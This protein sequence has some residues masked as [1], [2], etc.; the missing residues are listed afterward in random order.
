ML[1]YQTNF[2][3]KKIIF[4]SLAAIPAVAWAQDGAYTING[5][6]GTLN[7][8]AKAY[9]AYGRSMDTAEIKN[10]VFT[11][12][13]TAAKPTKAQI[14]VD[15]AGEG[16]MALRMKG[17]DIKPLYLEKGTITVTGKD[18]IYN[19][20]V[21]GTP[22]NVDAEKFNK[23]VEVPMKGMEALNK[24]YAAAPA[25]KKQDEAFVGGLRAKFEELNN[26]KNELAKKFIEQNPKSYLSLS[27]IQEIAGA[28]MDVAVVEPMFNKLD[29]SLRDSE[30]GKAFAKLI[31]A[32]HLTAVGVM[33]PDFTQN[34]VNDKPVKLSDF[35]GKYVLVDFWASWCGPCRAENP[36]VVK[37]YN[38]YKDKNFT[39]LGVSLDQ[40]GAKDKW[41][42]AIE[43]DGLAWTQVSDL[44][45]WD[46]DVAKLYGIRSIPQNFLLDPTGKIVG[47]NLRGE[48]LEAKLAE[49]IK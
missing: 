40:P 3:M 2:Y 19:A 21:A 34:D 45:F 17:A 46:N 10:G 43:K 7:A 31:A 12:K 37:A 15:H 20:A 36:N 30:E 4:L 38:T 13:G 48:A 22:I 29:A 41:V 39:V 8:P 25:D 33:A 28:S 35:K 18:S 9:L 32:A 42:A 14:I 49:L 24:E 6:V 44:K 11:F 16:L 1:H 5:K 23:F 27:A 26:Q 47:K